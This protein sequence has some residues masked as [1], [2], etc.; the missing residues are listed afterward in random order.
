MGKIYT[1]WEEGREKKV[2][3]VEGKSHV[4]IIIRGKV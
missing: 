2:T 3:H 4:R 1:N